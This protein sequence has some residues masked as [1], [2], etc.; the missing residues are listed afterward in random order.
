MTR[1][2]NITTGQIYEAVI[3]KERRGEY[4][5][6]TVQV[7]PH[8]TDEIKARILRCAEGLDVLDRRGR[9][10]RRRHR[11]AAVPRGRAPAARRARRAELG[12]RAPHARAVHR[13]RRRAQD[14]A[15][16]ALGPEAARD[17]HPARRAR[18]PL[19]AAARRG[20]C[21]KKMAMFC[22]V[23]ADAVFQSID[24]D[25]VYDCRSCCREQ[26]LDQ[27]LAGAPQHLVARVAARRRGKRS[28]SASPSRSARSRS[29]SSASTSS[30]SRRTR[31]STRRCSTAA[32]RTTASVEIQHIDSEELEKRAAPRTLARRTTASS[33]RPASARAAP[34][35]RSRRSATRASSKV[36]F[37]GIC[38]G[39][40]M[41]CIEFARH[42]CGL[43]GANSTEIDPATRAPGRRPDA[44][45]ARRH[46]QGRDDAPRRVPVRA[47]GR[48]RARPRPTARPRSASATATA[49]R[50]TTTTA[51]RSSATAW[52]CRGCRRTAGWSR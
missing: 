44:R 10:H 21:C 32:S 49:A 19:R 50:S 52:C 17:R 14:Q 4:L 38:F 28:S 8:I 18:L 34:R 40:Q 20:A 37:F 41:A 6:A 46:R 39:M 1:L 33:S 47:Q 24:V 30:S 5:G 22:N 35:A 2:N 25:T 27:K 29:A 42:V 7:I 36:P 15:D 43:D 26:G 23:A 45:P 48:A 3:A 31:A 12:Q 11:V 51:T 16:A 9:R 13:R